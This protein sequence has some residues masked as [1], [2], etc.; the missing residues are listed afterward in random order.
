[1]QGAFQSKKTLVEKNNFTKR[2]IQTTSHS[3]SLH[4]EIESFP[5]EKEKN[6]EAF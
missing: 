4:M 6:F 3:V 2:L 5:V 1:M